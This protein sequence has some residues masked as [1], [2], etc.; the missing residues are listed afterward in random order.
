MKLLFS[1]LIIS[2]FFSSVL[3]GYLA[4][5]LTKNSSYIFHMLMKRKISPVTFY[6]WSILIINIS[7]LIILF[8]FGILYL[9]LNENFLNPTI[10]YFLITFLFNFLVI[11]LILIIKGNINKH[12][13]H[14]V[15]FFAINSSVIYPLLLN[16]VIN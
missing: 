13:I 1:A 12:I 4:I 11:F 14:S 9:F 7:S 10:I 16:R 8:I 15:L 2:I 6:L 5:I 3:A